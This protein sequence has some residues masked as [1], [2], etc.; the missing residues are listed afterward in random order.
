MNTDSQNNITKSINSFINSKGRRYSTKSNLSTFSKNTKKTGKRKSKSS[1]KICEIDY[2]KSGIDTSK[3]NQIKKQLYCSFCANP[4]LKSALKFSCNHYLCSNCIS[5]QILK[6]G[7]TE[8]QSKTVEGIFNIDCP[9][10]S[11]NTEIILDELLSLLY[12][13]EDCLNHGEFTSCPKCS[14]W[15]S[16]LS[17]I[18]L[19]EIHRNN[20]EKKNNFEIVIKDYCLDCQKEL[21]GLCV[22]EHEGH[23]IKSLENIISDIQ[24]AKRKNQNFGEFYNFIN[25]IEDNF[26]K[27]YNREYEMNISKI[28]QA[29][30]KLM[31]IKKDFEETMKKKLNYSKN[32]FSLIKYIYYFYYTDLITVKN[33]IRVIDYLFK[34]KYELQNVSFNPK[35]DFS[36][37]L[38]TIL[39]SIKHLNIESF[40]CNINTKNAISSCFF[41]K[42]NAHNGYIFDILN[43]NDKYLVSA[44]EDRKIKLWSLNPKNFFI[45]IELD[46]LK[47]DSSVFSLCKDNL[48]KKFFSGSYGEIKI[49]SSE[50]FN[51]INILYGHKDYVTHME[52]IKKKINQYVNNITKDYLCSCSYDKTIKIW[53]LDS[54]NCVCTLEGHNDKVNYFFQDDKGFIISCSSDESIKLWNVDDEKCFHSL[55]KAHDGPVYCVTKTEEG[56]IVSCS[57]STIKIFDLERKK[58]D[59]IF[60]ENNKGIY[61]LLMLPGNKLASSSF[62][63]I[64]FWDLNKNTLLYSIEAHNNYITCLLILNDKLITSSDDGDIKIW[65]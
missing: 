61:K 45:N 26:N 43:I 44:G 14:L 6:K 57:F 54:L 10:N 25:L 13:D 24:R 8:C 4:I 42:Q 65:D 5:R 7:L 46:D 60:T 23:N 22:Q 37:K 15:T 40:D 27:D 41:E 63:Y 56:K 64:Y 2:S 21:C 36:L 39:D 47:H 29:I 52:M 34:N 49:W 18:K 16:V 11:G 9:C 28:N 35:L 32:I 30:N 48:G 50:D 59:T 12:I 31:E 3:Y 62:K 38:S 51:L 17:Q 33:N 53:D 1:S 55:D 19:C 20:F 58:V